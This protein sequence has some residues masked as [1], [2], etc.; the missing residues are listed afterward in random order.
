M[1]DIDYCLQ[2]VFVSPLVRTLQTAA[3][4]FGFHSKTP[5]GPVSNGQELAQAV[6]AAELERTEH[7]SVQAPKGLPMIVTS[8]CRERMG[9]SLRAT[10]QPS[11]GS[12]VLRSDVC[13]QMH[14][15]N[16]WSRQPSDSSV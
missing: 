11:A 1:T 8:K 12:F 10:Q 13:M 2:V 4:V 9:E 15:L 14:N 7:V 16:V 3:G 5:G 6:S